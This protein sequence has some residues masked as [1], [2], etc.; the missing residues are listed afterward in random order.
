MKK[1]V[2]SVRITELDD[3]SDRLLKLYDGETA[4][5]NEP[6]LK[7]LFAEMR[8]LWEKITDAIHRDRISSDLKKADDVR[9]NAVISLFKAIDGY[10]HISVDALRQPAERLNK[11]LAKFGTRITREN[12]STESSLIEALLSD[13]HS[14]EAITDVGALAG[15]EETI[16]DVRSAQDDFTAKRVAYEKTVAAQQHRESASVLKKPL[17]ELIN[18]KLLPYLDT[19]KMAD[20]TKYTVLADASAQAVADTNSAIAQRTK[21]R[22]PPSDDPTL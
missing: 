17:L 19:M 3:T 15:I 2:T 13:L 18:K 8:T 5:K 21:P 6:F 22:N 1:L 10:A 4:L 12:Y 7:P 20:P 11:I 9:D 16:A 14:D